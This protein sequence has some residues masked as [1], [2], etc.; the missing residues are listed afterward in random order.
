MTYSRDTTA[1]SEIT[2]Q[3]VNTWSEEWQH[4]CEARALL[5]M[6]KDERE[7][8]LARA[9]GLRG[10]QAVDGLKTLMDQLLNVRA[11]K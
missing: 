11:A 3:P 6:A 2:G 5:K 9:K 4:E 1:L 10:E 8:F 7:A